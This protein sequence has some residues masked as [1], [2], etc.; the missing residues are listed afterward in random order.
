MSTLTPTAGL[1]PG[2]GIAARIG[3]VRWTICA[4]LFVATTINYMDRQVISILKP[5]LEHSIGLTESGYGHVVAVF[6]VAYA[7][8]L[9]V[10]GRLVDR[11]GSR[12]GYTVIMATWSA[13]AMAHALVS[14]AFGFGVARLFL[15]LGESGNFPAAVKTVA[16]W[17]PKRERSL[18]TGLFN[19]GATAGAI[20]APLTVPWITMHYGWHAAFLFTGL[21]GLPWIVWW[22]VNYRTPDDHPTLTSEELRHI[23]EDNA[24][25]MGPKLP[26]ARLL[27]YRQT[28]GIVL[29]KFL[30]DPIWWFYLF[31]IPG[32]LDTRFHVDLQHLGLPLIVVY[33]VSTVGGVAGGWLPAFFER[34]GI[35]GSRARY[36]AMFVC[37]CFSLP[38][39]FAG[40][41]TSEWLAVALL[42]LAAA[43]HQGWSANLYTT[44]S[45]V[46]PSS[47]VGSV[48][49]IAGM[50]GSLGGTLLSL[51][52]GHI[53]Q[54]THS[55]NSLF[56][57]AGS[58][59]MVAFVC[60]QVFAPGLRRAN[61]EVP[62]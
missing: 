18:A 38:M 59:Y 30:T 23:Y 61:V 33:A 8:G 22:Y 20:I 25:Q 47:A 49:G 31:W 7:I 53:L 21:L 62:A 28:W 1:Q 34:M 51:E 19:S 57:L 45:D 6:Q 24:E 2:S 4:M 55:Y 17:F 9:L 54:L 43:G 11:V 32:F 35:R 29:A 14:T 39:L 50:A 58:V 37:A 41:V 46:F 40:R 44:A 56:I 3:H 12:I 27:G 10:A 48:I 26:W 15:G 16:D 36:G 5:T 60:L 13:A 42:S 52:A